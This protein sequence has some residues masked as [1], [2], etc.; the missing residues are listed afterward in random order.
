[1]LGYAFRR[2]RPM[3]NYIVD[4]IC[5]RLKLVIEVDGYTHQLGENEVKDRI[6]QENIEKAGFI[7]IRF[8]DEEVLNGMNQVRT[9]IQ[10]QIDLI[11]NG[12]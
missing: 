2:Q 4:F 8:K 11:V 10:N 6:R 3:S 12:N 5:L 9:S 1:M 7:V